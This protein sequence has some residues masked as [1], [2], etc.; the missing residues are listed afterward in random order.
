MLHHSHQV[1]ATDFPNAQFANNLV[2]A[3]SSHSKVANV[4]FFRLFSD[5]RKDAE[6]SAVCYSLIEIAKANNLE[7]QVYIEHVI[8]HIAVA[9][10][11]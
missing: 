6:A 10:V 5:T 1:N 7:P 9:V 11:A 4:F 2:R 8:D 3:L